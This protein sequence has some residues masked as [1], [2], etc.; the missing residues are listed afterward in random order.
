M[1]GIHEVLVL[2]GMGLGSLLQIAV[3]AGLYGWARRVGKVRGGWF[4]RARFL[5]LVGVASTL[6]GLCVTSGF[7]VSAFSAVASAPPDERSLRLADGIA[8]AMNA[9]AIGLALTLVLYLASFAS[10][11]V[12][13][14]GPQPER[15]E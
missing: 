13:T 15:A 5:P 8:G 4:Q 7:L 14:W 11:A 3:P 6:L 2:L 12:G 1:V 9:T 10:S